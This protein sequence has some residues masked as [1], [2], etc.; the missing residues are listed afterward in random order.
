MRGAVGLTQLATLGSCLLAAEAIPWRSSRTCYSHE[1]IWQNAIWLIS[2]HG[3]PLREVHPM[4]QGRFRYKKNGTEWSSRDARMST[5]AIDLPPDSPCELNFLQR[6]TRCVDIPKQFAW[7][8]TEKTAWIVSDSSF[9]SYAHTV[10][11]VRDAAIICAP[12]NSTLRIEHPIRAYNEQEIHEED[13]QQEFHDAI[14]LSSMF[15]VLS[16][17]CI[18]DNC[19]TQNQGRYARVQLRRRRN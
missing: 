8:D 14:I 12:S 16:C 3:H 17:W 6:L 1:E 5:L 18:C 10:M 13:N 9:P 7:C 4:E 19:G 2:C 11:D 15:A